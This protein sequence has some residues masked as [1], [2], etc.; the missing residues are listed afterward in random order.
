MEV[1]L[2]NNLNEMI[3]EYGKVQLQPNDLVE[4]KLNHVIVK[5]EGFLEFTVIL[6]EEESNRF[7]G[8]NRDLKMQEIILNY[9]GVYG[10][11]G[12][13]EEG[14]LESA[15]TLEMFEGRKRYVLV[16]RYEGPYFQVNSGLNAGRVIIP[17]NKREDFEFV[18]VYR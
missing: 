4:L 14:M 15:R 17:T 12:N 9:K 11:Y 5:S 16:L 18:E 13:H 6:N 2:F 10:Y 7:I 3:H 8:N 1:R